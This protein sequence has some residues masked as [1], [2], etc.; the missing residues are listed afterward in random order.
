MCKSNNKYLSKKF[1]E[2]KKQSISFIDD[3]LKQLI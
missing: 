1:M 3:N 2:F